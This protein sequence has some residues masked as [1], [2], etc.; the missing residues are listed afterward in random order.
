MSNL[1]DY[2][3]WRGDLT[4]EER[5]FCEVDQLV[6]CEL[7]YIDWKELVPEVSYGENSDDKNSDGKNS[8]GESDGS[9]IREVTIAEAAKR[10]TNR[11]FPAAPDSEDDQ[12]EKNEFVKVLGE[13][14]RFGGLKLFDYVDR[15]GH[16]G[17]ATDF[18]AVTIRLDENTIFVVYR[19]TV[20][21]IV[22]WKEDF[23][24][25]YQIIPAQTYAVNYLELAAADDAVKKIYV[26]GHSK[27]GNLALYAASMCKS[28][29]QDKIV[30]VYTNDG[31]GLC[32][33]I[34][35]D[36]KIDVIR[37]RLMRYVPE[38]S[39]F[40]ALFKTEANT[41]IVKSTGS[42]IMQHAM[43]TWQVEGDEFVSS[44][45]HSEDSQFLNS[46]LSRWIEQETMENREAFV[47]SLFDAFEANGITGLNDLEKSGVDDLMT[48]LLSVTNSDEKTKGTMHRFVRTVIT[49][50]GSVNFDTFMRE[51]ESIQVLGLFVLGFLISMF[52]SQAL[53]LVGV[54]IGIAGTVFLGKRLLD[55]AFEEKGTV[56]ARKMKVVLHMAGM[57]ILMYL[58][59]EKTILL[60]MTNLFIGI[61][62]LV[63]A[64]KWLTKAFTYKGWFPKRALS[65]VIAGLAF[66]VGMVPL[67]NSSVEMT[68]YMIAAG[69]FI[70]MYAV[71]RFVYLA[72][73]N[74]KKNK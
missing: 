2:I 62:F 55:T 63:F 46:I 40:G 52:P 25:S 56:D 33:E 34:V 16:D 57:C 12:T 39:V 11:Q 36:E 66:A 29:V 14:K 19:G 38:F 54:A 72:Y 65:L 18:S 26:A 8:D 22:G 70:W 67:I 58:V 17:P 21:S 27:G 5:P 3:K 37:D 59:A 9:K 53:R 24:M 10:Y 64:Y 4:F 73:K 28:E 60:K 44:K 6:F 20:D 1:I 69:C 41:V 49:A 32:K 68:E 30:K 45:K 74:G 71:A 7:S 47:N 42:G 50:I 13:S 48:I 23:C 51:K 31:P 43:E 15:L 61:A 35:S